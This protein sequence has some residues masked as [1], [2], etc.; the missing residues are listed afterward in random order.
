M[1]TAQAPA[2][3]RALG[4]ATDADSA[5]QVTQAVANCSQNISHRGTVSL[6]GMPFSQ[7]NGVLQS[8]PWT[9]RANNYYGTDLPPMPAED[10]LRSGGGLGYANG[11]NPFEMPSPGGGYRSGDWYTF[12]GDNNVFDV[13]PRITEQTNFYY[14]APTFVV[15]GNSS[16]NWLHA[17]VGSF[18]K[19]QAKEVEAAVVNGEPVRGE[20]GDPGAAGPAGAPGQRGDPGLAIIG[21]NGANGVNGLNGLNGVVWLWVQNLPRVAVAQQ[22]QIQRIVGALRTIRVTINEDCSV[23]VSSN[24]PDII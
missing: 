7:S 8:S 9:M 3:L 24:Y 1:F 16:M 18:E 15:A 19:V 23:S 13:A 4:D 12:Q 5:R 6:A 21:P 20:K 11:P 10:A 14:G 17:N 2:L 22:Q